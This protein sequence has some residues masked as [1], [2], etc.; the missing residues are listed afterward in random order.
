M[1]GHLLELSRRGRFKRDEIEKKLDRNCEGLLENTE[2]FVPVMIPI[3]VM[4]YAHLVFDT[5][6]QKTSLVVGLIPAILLFVMYLLLLYRFV[7]LRRQ[8]QSLCL[9]KREMH[10][11]NQTSNP[12]I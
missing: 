2:Y 10:E 3:P 8:T 12:M 5:F 6:G 7:Y 11:E 9:D 4:I 1:F